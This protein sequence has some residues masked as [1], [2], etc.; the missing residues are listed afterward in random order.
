MGEGETTSTS[1]LMR[2]HEFSVTDL[3]PGEYMLQA[4]AASSSRDRRLPPRETAWVPIRLDADVA[5]LPVSTMRGSVV[6]GRVAFQG[7]RPPHSGVTVQSRRED[8]LARAAGDRPVIAPVSADG[9]FVL[10]GVFG[11]QLLRVSGLPDGWFVRAVR[12][13]GRDIAHVPTLFPEGT[14]RGLEVVASSDGGAHLSAVVRDSEGKLASSC[15]VVLVPV[16]GAKWGIVSAGP[17]EPFPEDGAC[18]LGVVGPGEYF[19]LASTTAVPPSLFRRN[20]LVQRLLESGATR[21]TLAPGDRTSVEVRQRNVP[22]G[23]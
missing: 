11:P 7:E 23:R 13:G 16:E 8:D 6:T 5:G 2:G 20:R 12:Y 14:A 4:S 18:D 9:T 19:V 22:E 15:S 10:E 17:R 3:E 21:I 1:L